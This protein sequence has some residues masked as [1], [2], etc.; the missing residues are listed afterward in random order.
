MKLRRWL[1]GALLSVLLLGGWFTA[2]V[3]G[4]GPYSAQ[5]Q[6]AIQALLQSNAVV[7]GNWTCTGVC[8]GFGGTA[9]SITGTITANQVAFGTGSQTIGGSSNLTWNGSTLATTGFSQN[10]H[11][12]SLAG[13]FTTSGAFAT[14][15]TM[16]GATTLTM[17]TVGTLATLTDV[18]AAITA[19]N[20]SPEA[21]SGTFLVSG[22]QVVW[23]S[24]YS[25]LVS[26]ATYYINGIQ[27]TSPQAT[28]T[29][30]GANATLDRLD[31]FIVDATSTA[32]VITGTA[33]NPPVEPTVDP[34]TQ[35][36]LALAFV[37]HNT[38]SP[39]STTS[40]LVYDE[41][42]GPATEYTWTSSGSG[43]ALAS[44][45]NPYHGTK[46]IEATTVASGSYILGTIGSGSVDPTAY[47]FLNFF[48][49]SKGTWGTKS[50]QL[51]LL[52]S[53]GAVLGKT[54]T[55]AN[56]TYG[57]DSTNTTS[58]QQI[59]VPTANF[60][61][62]AGSAVAKVQLTRAGNGN[63][64]FYFDYMQWLGSNSNTTLPNGT[65][66]SF[67][68]T[69]SIAANKTLTAS[70]TLTLVGTD[71]STIT[72]GAG[73][74]VVYTTTTQTLTNKSLT[75]RV[76]TP[77]D[78]TSIT[79]NTDSADMTYQANTQSAGTLTIN[80]DGGTPS[81]GQRWILKIKS[82]NVQTF[83]WSSSANGYLG[84]TTALPTATTGGTKVD[85]FAFLFDGIS[86]KWHYVGTSA[87]F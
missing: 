1:T 7:S 12:V 16:T 19:A 5:I 39:P 78:A 79:P 6:A 48:I 23:Q 64:G 47:S 58:Y 65:S 33:S 72:L 36:A 29:L 31:T 57:F 75:P 81:N 30:A 17:P 21:A 70:N 2:A 11:A 71:A 18:I 38:T 60:G 84:G 3:N 77:A 40:A 86:G 27:Y 8:S 59:A 83:S 43:W 14:T 49:R 85:Y 51:R 34:S 42:V 37:T 82:T 67:P 35:L 45:N 50:L 28:L 44:T 76:A 10:G 53:S 13:A 4:Q 46:D 52:N 55:I 41:D 25:Y 74:T 26:S 9:S 54:I 63:I 32:S 66:L 56:G 24:G 62:N 15:L 80:A 68:G 87:G 61:V 20:G 22:G 73:G 69:L